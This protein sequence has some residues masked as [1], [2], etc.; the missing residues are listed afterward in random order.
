LEEPLDLRLRQREPYPIVEVRNPL[1]KT[2]YLVLRPTYPERTPA[3]CTCTD[4]A[5]RGLGT[6]KHIEAADRWL[7]NH[8][9]A[10][11]APGPKASFSPDSAWQEID[12]RLARAP[13]L[14]RPDIVRLRDAGAALFETGR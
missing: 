13:T 4:F 1:H 10:T 7:S 12:R 5:R 9:T 2:S 14:H 3:L 8:P 11:P 6:C